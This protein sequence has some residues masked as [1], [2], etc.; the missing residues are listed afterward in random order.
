[1]SMLDTCYLLP[2]VM[3]N[4]SPPI[5]VQ[6][7]IQNPKVEIVYIFVANNESYRNQ[8]IEFL[9]SYKKWPPGSPH[10]TTIVCNNG[11]PSPPL[12]AR[13]EQLPEC[14]FLAHDNSGYDIGGFQHA[15][16]QSTADL[17]LFLGASTYF[18]GANWLQR[19]INTYVQFGD[20]LY[21]TM[22]NRGDA[23]V[24]VNRHIRST[25]FWCTPH[26]FNQYPFT[27]IDLKQRYEFEHKANCITE[28]LMRGGLQPLVV[29]WNGVYQWEHWDDDPNGYNRGNQSGVMIGDHLTRAY[30]RR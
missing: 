30:T 20:T 8:A 9:D 17:M 27:V 18:Q 24:N 23:H 29:T 1:M 21:G 11:M 4:G 25:A 7:T 12:K 13:F 28:W 19:V 6:P 5:K 10:Q 2:R 16:R 22:G 15:A 14:K 26:L 3:Q